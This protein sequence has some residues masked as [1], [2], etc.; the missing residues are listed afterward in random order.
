MC[1]V[2]KCDVCIIDICFAYMLDMVGNACCN[3]CFDQA[4]LRHSLCDQG[5]GPHS[6][7][8]LFTTFNVVYA[9]CNAHFDQFLP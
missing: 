8:S 5:W 6:A 4:L 2:L 3:D 1:V 9:V 7:Q